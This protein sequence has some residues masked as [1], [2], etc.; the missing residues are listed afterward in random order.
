MGLS[1]T[2]HP[3]IKVGDLYKASRV[4]AYADPDGFWLNAGPILYLGEDVINRGDGV[5]IVNHAVIVRGQR[6]ILDRS[7]LKFLE[8]WK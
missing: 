4:G 6:R 1:H 5:R 2:A 3:F 8:P 7:F